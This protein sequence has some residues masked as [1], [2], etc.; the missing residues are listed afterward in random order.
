MFHQERFD[1][2]VACPDKSED[3]LDPLRGALLQHGHQWLG[4][5]NKQEGSNGASLSDSPR[6]WNLQREHAIEMHL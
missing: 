5:Q 3:R 2:K 6:Q 4:G 1:A